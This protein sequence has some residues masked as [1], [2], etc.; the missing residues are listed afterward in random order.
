M[1]KITKI[2]RMKIKITHRKKRKNLILKKKKRKL[3]KEWSMLIKKNKRFFLN[4]NNYSMDLIFQDFLSKI[5]YL[6]ILKILMIQK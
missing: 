1:K 4:L 3:L 5:I 2:I 6:N